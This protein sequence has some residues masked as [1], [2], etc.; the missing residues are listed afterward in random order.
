MKDENVSSGRNN[1]Q[2][3]ELTQGP[4]GNFKNIIFSEDTIREEEGTQIQQNKTKTP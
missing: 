2:E 4:K 3:T 1:L